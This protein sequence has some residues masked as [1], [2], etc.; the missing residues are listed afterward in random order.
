LG[1]AF[2]FLVIG[3][4]EAI[5]SL[6]RQHLVT[7]APPLP[8][9][10]ADASTFWT[11][12]DQYSGFSPFPFSPGEPPPPHSKFLKHLH[13]SLHAKT[14]PPVRAPQI[15]DP[16]T[17]PGTRYIFP[18]FG[19]KHYLTLV[20]SLF[21]PID[22]GR[23]TL[24]AFSLG[25]PPSRKP[26]PLFGVQDVLL[27]LRFHIGPMVCFPSLILPPSYELEQHIAN[28]LFF[29]TINEK[30][31]WFQFPP[32]QTPPMIPFSIF[33]PVDSFSRPFV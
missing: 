3:V 19:H 20:S 21:P 4:L 14:P 1:F 11:S 8:F 26:F 24:P 33:P 17:A 13:L 18:L 31:E 7:P 9:Y 12:L 10:A 5:R 16:P 23:T 29:P 32:F 22:L 6:R 2:L 15:S 27:H 28:Y 30:K 25:T